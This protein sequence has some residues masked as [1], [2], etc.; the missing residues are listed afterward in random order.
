MPTLRS[1][2]TGAA[3]GADLG[4][5]AASD[6]PVL[7]LLHGF[8][9]KP[10]EWLPISARI[11]PEGAMLFVFPE[12]PE[13]T[14]PPEGRAGG[15][16]WWKLDLGSQVDPEDPGA[17]A[18]LSGMSPPGM[19]TARERLVAFLDDL[20]RLGVDSS[21]VILG[22]FSQGAMVALDLALHDRRPLRGLAL[23]SGTI[24]NERDWFTRLSSRRGLPVLIAHG[25]QDPV[26]PF[27]LA[28][29]LR[30]ALE[31]AR[32]QVTWQPFDAGHAIPTVVVEA[33]AAFARGP[34]IAHV[35][36][37]SRGRRDPAVGRG[38]VG[39]AGRRVDGSGGLPARL[40]AG[41]P[42]LEKDLDRAG[43]GQRE[44]GPHQAP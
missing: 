16:A 28:Q 43:D 33:L 35:S 32:W 20:E 38:Y 18:D 11:G 3:D 25:R 34:G 6:G 9:S 17:P 44:K 5:L 30:H 29:R 24:V 7:V 10:S 31:A 36:S 1:I 27:A 4:A 23:L 19:V 14:A 37:V 13:P 41:Q 15:R 39:Q 22:G 21:R 26:L 2:S 40:A 8:A 12:G 42:V